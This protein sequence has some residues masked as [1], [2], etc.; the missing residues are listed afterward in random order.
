MSALLDA[1]L[2]Y[3]AIGWP[4]FPCGRD[5]APLTD[6]GV[7][8][9]TTDPAKISAWWTEFPNANIGFH[10]GAAGMMALDFDPGH[11]MADVHRAVDGLPVT[12]LCQITPRGGRH[13]FYA[14]DPGERIAP[15]AGKVALNVDVRSH[16]SYVLLAPSKTDVGEYYWEHWPIHAMPKPAYRTAAM[17]AACGT[18][19]AKHKNADVWLIA[20]DLPENITAAIAWI[21]SDACRPAIEEKGGNM[22]T[23]NTGAMMRSFGLSE[24]MANEVMLATFN[25]TKCVPAWAPDEMAVPVANAYRYATSPPGNRTTA[26]KLAL[27]RSLLKVVKPADDRPG[28]RAQV[29]RF[30]ALDAEA[31]DMTPDPEWLIPDLIQCS[32][33]V[34]MVGAPGSFK[35]FLGLDLAL[36]VAVGDGAETGRAWP[37]IP[38][39]GAAIFAAGEGGA[40]LKL[41]RRAWELKHNAG[42]PVRNFIRVTNVPQINSEADALA[43]IEVAKAMRP[44]GYRIAVIDTAMRAM[45]GANSNSQEAASALTKLVSMISAELAPDEYGCTVLVLHHPGQGVG[46]QDKPA[47]SFVFVGDPDTLL[48]V[49]RPAKGMTVALSMTK[50]KD[51]PEWEQPR[52]V[53]LE[54]VGKSLVAVAGSRPAAAAQPPAQPGTG[55]FKPVEDSPSQHN[56][57][58]AIVKAELTAMF[59]GNETRVWESDR[60]VARALANRLSRAGQEGFG[61]DTLRLKY[62]PPIRDSGYELYTDGEWGMKPAMDALKNGATTH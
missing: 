57:K 55:L 47:G 48:A 27:V 52:Y 45:Q 2:G 53:T 30:I 42:K 15:S 25:V 46:V 35:S 22:M 54:P 14:L 3:A 34:M 59:K 60:D 5:K 41:R 56:A 12:K 13:Q 33:Y 36:S 11:N 20:P 37:S 8:D 19:T 49:S 51:A 9:A 4:I 31:D 18:A 32:T 38:R 17:V 50:Q 23:F 29:G 24:D 39:P 61:E 40:G 21:D 1:A 44:E 62:L 7:L 28:T 43:F 58:L 16:N 26:Y 6:N 10:V